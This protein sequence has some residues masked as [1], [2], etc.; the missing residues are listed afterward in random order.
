MSVLGSV[1]IGDFHSK[2]NVS[3]YLLIEDKSRISGYRVACGVCDDSCSHCHGSTN[4]REMQRELDT[5]PHLRNANK[6][7]HI[8]Q[9][10][11]TVMLMITV[12]SVS[13]VKALAA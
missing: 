13:A 9:L 3:G 5:S 2:L 6:S 1:S 4:M 10:L 11:L 12:L 8:V 7:T